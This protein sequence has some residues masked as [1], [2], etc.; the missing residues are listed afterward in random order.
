MSFAITSPQFAA[1][2]PIPTQFTCDGDDVSP[3][4]EWTEPPEGTVTLALIMED[5]DAPINTFTHWLLWNL[6]PETRQL[7]ESLAHAKV[8]SQPAGAHQGHNDFGRTG[9]GGPCPPPGKPHRYFFRLYALDR[10]LSVE[11]GARRMQVQAAMRNHV[12][13]ETDLMGRYQRTGK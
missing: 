1:G 9:Y 3:A 5:P 12:L 13:A 2:D 8:L 10:A 11:P 4:L 7:R 6:P